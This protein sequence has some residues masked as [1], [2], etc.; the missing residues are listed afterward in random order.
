MATSSDAAEAKI[1]ILA[2]IACA[3]PGADTV[4]Q[5]HLS[6]PTNT[7]IL[8]IPAPVMLP[9]HF[10]FQALDKG[11]GGIIVMTC[12]EECPYK[13][14]YHR[15]ASRMDR[16]AAKMKAE[17]YDRRRIKLTAICTVCT[18]AFLKEVNE[19]NALLKE[20]GPPR[21]GEAGN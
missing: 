16:V 13:G 19:M 9:E 12:G 5:A 20:I 21:K 18:K 1:L 8:R 3:Y 2:T 7:Y 14:A 4:G 11:I 10:Y 15:L 6:Y 17:G